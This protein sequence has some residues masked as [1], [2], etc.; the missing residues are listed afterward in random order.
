MS[1][2]DE[3]DA[4][5]GELEQAELP[6]ALVGAVA[7]WGAP[8]AT[9]DIDLLVREEDLPALLQR[10]AACGFD[11]PAG[12]MMFS[13]GM[14]LQRV[15]KVSG[16]DVLTLDFMLLDENL[17]PAWRSRQRVETERGS[18]WTI[19]RD[20]L[21]AMK[22]QAARPQDLYDVQRMRELDR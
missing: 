2:A 4:L 21:I 22:L 3:L 17:E 6:Y 15:S 12:P 7:V 9:K 14:R 8:R 5:L 10:A 20:A 18:L 11:F 19:S 13:D 1:L 16:R